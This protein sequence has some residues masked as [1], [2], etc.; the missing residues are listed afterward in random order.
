MVGKERRKGRNDCAAL[1]PIPPPSL[2]C[3]PADVK[4]HRAASNKPRTWGIVP[5]CA[6]LA[7][8]IRFTAALRGSSASPVHP[9]CP[10]LQVKTSLHFQLQRD[11]TN[12]FFLCSGAAPGDPRAVTPLAH[13]HPA[14]LTPN[15]SHTPWQLGLCTS[16]P[17][18]P[19]IPGYCFKLVQKSNYCTK[20]PSET[21]PC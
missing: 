13:P 1:L 12:L 15:P 10:K 9:G 3:I 8:L 21:F 18:L 2:G 19:W 7:Q 17:F 11:T 6:Q 20:N 4:V 16:H 5:S 14:L